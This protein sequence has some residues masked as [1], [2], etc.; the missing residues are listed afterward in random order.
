MS[1]H[2]NSLPVKSRRALVWALSF[3]L[4]STLVHA[5]SPVADDRRLLQLDDASDIHYPGAP[6]ISPD[7]RNIAFDLEEKIFVASVD[8]GST[9]PVT[10]SASTASS[11]RWSGD[12][13]WL[14]FVSD[15]SGS[16]QLWKL[17]VDGFGEAEQ[18]SQLA[19]GV[20]STNVSPDGTRVLLALKD[21]DLRDTT[22]ESVPEPFVVV[23]RQFKRDSGDGYIT[24][25]RID[26]LYI[27]ETGSDTLTQIT[28]GRYE[29]SEAAW[30][31]DGRSIVFVSNREHEPGL[32]YRSD[33]WVV[34]A[35]N[36]DKGSNPRR[37]TD[38]VHTKQSPV[39]SPDG[40]LIAYIDA[41]DGIFGIQSIALVPSS[42]GNPRILTPTLDRWVT[43]FEFSADGKWIY[44][45]YDDAGSSR[46]ARVRIRD[47]LVEKLVDGD[48]NVTEFS[49]SGKGTVAVALNDRN[50]TT[51]IHLLRDKHLE[52]L[53]RLNDDFFATIAAGDKTK[54]SFES[55]DG[56]VV[57]AFITTPP[58]YDAGQRYPAILQIHG[59]PLGQVVWGYD[60]SA[61]YFAANGYVVVEPNPRGSTGRGQRYIRAIYQ[62]WGI[63]DYDDVIAAVDYAVGQGIADPKRLA[64][65]GYSYGGY[66]TNVVITRTNRFK[67]A[68]TGAGHSLIEA[69]FGH[70]IYQ[71][72]YSWELGP[73]WENRDKYDHLS[74]LLR[75]ANVQTPTLF[76]GGSIDWNVPIL[77][78]ELFYQALR[79]RGIRTE[80]VV[81]PGVHH[82]DWPAE[83][84][85]DYLR[86]VVQWFD[87]F[88][89]SG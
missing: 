54:V 25:D 75:A 70:D 76:L 52:R 51:D 82:G 14:Y 33:L 43:A 3:A 65:T 10:S 9:H 50:D 60:F 35:D 37:L 20:T 87:R 16:M 23:R 84:E 66:M 45:N 69:N 4:T 36:K 40:K 6:R 32:D 73:P 47:G 83:Y 15:R 12:G 81:Y 22:E 67:A 42:G 68:A 56:T 38:D 2:C 85:K 71:Q 28:S 18:L 55:P 53:T 63:T 19:T 78:A 21:S 48:R 79:V 89:K 5:A 77:N 34:A 31:P 49:V 7:G 58:G 8:G 62:T 64:V 29:E 46:L 72:W 27:Y 88:A 57:E 17:A 44:F 61:Q 86:R 41:E 74:P 13:A 80:L 11:P 59:G 24:E 39:W 26:H 1:L 30:S